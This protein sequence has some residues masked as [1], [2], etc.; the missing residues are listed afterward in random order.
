LLQRLP[1]LIHVPG[2]QGQ[3]EQGFAEI[4]QWIARES[5]S[6]QLGAEVILNRLTEM[7]FIQVIRLWIE[8]QDRAGDGWAGALR[9]Q[10]VSTALGLIHHSPQR[11]WTV[12]ELAQAAGLSRAAFS[13]RFTQTVGE[14]PLTYLTRWRMLKATGLLKNEVGM[15]TIAE[16]LGYESEAAFRKAFKRELGIPPAHYRRFG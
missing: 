10:P 5:A 8:G 12:Q 4:V 1:K 2:A 15:E 13:A 7:L 9:D 14:P 16:Q 3:M 11:K 6:R